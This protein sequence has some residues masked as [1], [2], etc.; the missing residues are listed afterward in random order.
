MRGF[1]LLLLSVITVNI[2]PLLHRG[3]G[4]KDELEA[5]SRESPSCDT[6]QAIKG[7]LKWSEI[8]KKAFCFFTELLEYNGATETMC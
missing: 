5:T 3:P 1:I 4:S 2:P 6:A 8:S 7:E